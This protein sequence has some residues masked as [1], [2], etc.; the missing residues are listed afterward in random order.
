MEILPQELISDTYLEF[1]SNVT[2]PLADVVGAQAMKCGQVLLVNGLL[3]KE[4]DENP[5]CL[6]FLQEGFELL[7]NINITVIV[8][9]SGL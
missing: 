5:V 9:V 2:L 4:G 8:G 6:W 1:S 7:L 3:L